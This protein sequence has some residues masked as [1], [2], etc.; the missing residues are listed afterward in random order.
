MANHHKNE[1]QI[2]RI[3]PRNQRTAEGN[4]RNLRKTVKNDFGSDMEDILGADIT[5]QDRTTL[6]DNYDEIM[7][8]IDEL[9]RKLMANR[10][11]KETVAAKSRN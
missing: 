4:L 8:T 2:G 5:K 3:K 11:F 7:K 1:N 9:Q 10:H 6:I